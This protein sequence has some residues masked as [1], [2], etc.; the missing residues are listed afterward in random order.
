M[1]HHLRLI[2][3]QIQFSRD[4]NCVC[5]YAMAV[6]T[7]EMTFGREVGHPSRMIDLSLRHRSF[8]SWHQR[9]SSNFSPAFSHSLALTASIKSSNPFPSKASRPAKGTSHI[10]DLGPDFL[11][12]KH[13]SQNIEKRCLQIDTK[14][15]SL[16]RPDLHRFLNRSKQKGVISV[17]SQIGNLPSAECW[18]SPN[19][20]MTGQHCSS[21]DFTLL[22]ALSSARLVSSASNALICTVFK[23]SLPSYTCKS[24]QQRS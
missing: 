8:R 3:A 15:Q 24:S 23:Q 21:N 18:M 6:V 10:K 11:P 22:A 4:L 1:Y 13:L 12:R 20:A 17:L 9:V 7:N 5:L 19:T 14:L 16:L 2:T